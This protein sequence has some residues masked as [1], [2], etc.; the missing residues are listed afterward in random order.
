[1]RVHDVGPNKKCVS[2]IED[3]TCYAHDKDM[4]NFVHASAEHYLEEGQ[5]IAGKA[6]Q[7]NHPF[8]YPDV[9]EYHVS[10]YPLVHH[11]R[12]FGLNAAIA[13]RLRS[14]YT[15]DSDY[16]LELFLPLNVKGSIE[17]QILLNNLS[18]T[19]QRICKS[20]RTV[21]HTELL[22]ID[23]SNIKLL[24][25]IVETLPART[26]CRSYEQSLIEGESTFVN[27]LT[28]NASQLIGV[29]CSHEQVILRLILCP[30]FK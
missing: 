30:L 23:D 29:E 19:M 5:G 24:D 10:D 21:S 4:E 22:K 16:I 1:M 20:L 3:T 2:C 26:L 14:T 13:I 18:I 6:F 8:F 17:H 28:E 12:K 9:K 25:N 11:A 27:R 7:S 15:G